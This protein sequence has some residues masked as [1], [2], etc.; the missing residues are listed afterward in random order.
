[1]LTRRNL[2]GLF[3]ALGALAVPAAAKS[4][5]AKIEP[6]I[7]EHTCDWNRNRYTASEITEMEANGRTYW[8]CGTKFQWHFGVQPY[9][10][11]CGYAYETTLELLRRGVYRI[12]KGKL[13]E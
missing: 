12:V 1:M 5:E 7:L 13:P 3:P 4:E 10:P 9:C 6:I 8:G 11:K 2:F